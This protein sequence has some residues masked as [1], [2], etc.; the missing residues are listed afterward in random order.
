VDGAG[1]DGAGGDG[2]DAAAARAAVV[3]APAA[4]AAAARP[5]RVLCVED[6]PVNL[7]LVRE[8]LALRPG[9]QL[10]SAEDGASA[11]ALAS[12]HAPELLLLDMQLP[13][14][15]GIELMGALRALPQ[16]AASTFVALSADAVSEHVERAL[17]AGFD[18]YWTKPIDF[19]HFLAEFDR[20]AA[21]RAG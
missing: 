6:N 16:C 2:S 13:D 7:L 4:P 9:V 21:A 14:M 11:L 15:H 10:A 3:T 5:L 20:L 12:E 8:L 18:A 19:D 17:A 1:G